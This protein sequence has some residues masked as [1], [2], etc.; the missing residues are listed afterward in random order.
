MN[1]L[2]S[3]VECDGLPSTWTNMTTNTLFPV[4]AGTILVMAC[5]DGFANQGA[6]NVTCLANSTYSYSAEPQCIN[7]NNVNCQFPQGISGASHEAE[8]G[9]ALKPCA[10]PLILITNNQ[11]VTCNE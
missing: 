1:R 10:V 3:D 9:G 11:N 8:G 2:F 4:P 5:N 7:G 6:S